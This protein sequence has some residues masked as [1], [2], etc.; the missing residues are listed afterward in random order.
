MRNFS[1]GVNRRDLILYVIGAIV[2]IG[3]TFFWQAALVGP[4]GS[5]WAGNEQRAN[6]YFLTVVMYGVAVVVTILSYLASL[7][8]ADRSGRRMVPGIMVRLGLALEIFGI[9][10]T[11]I[12]LAYAGDPQRS[13]PIGFTAFS[14]VFV[15]LFI[16]GFGGNMLAPKR[17]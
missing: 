7:R 3:F 10:I 15:G 17:V 14:T 4:I 1:L 2:A 8:D 6:K 9:L 16:A 5:L 13:V 12:A 11:P